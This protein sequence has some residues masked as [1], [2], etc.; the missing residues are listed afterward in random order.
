MKQVEYEGHLYS[1]GTLDAMAQLGVARRLTPLSVL[2]QGMTAEEN[3]DKDTT[4]LVIL[5][6]GQLSDADNDHVVK[7][8]LSV[9]KIQQM[10]SWAPV[11]APGGAMMFSFMSMKVIVDLTTQ[12]ILENLGGFF[13]TALTDTK[14]RAETPAS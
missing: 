7:T 5:M 12:V 14:V 9:V 4:V 13:R 2:I 3:K 6:L 10:D 8:C 1:I 11:T